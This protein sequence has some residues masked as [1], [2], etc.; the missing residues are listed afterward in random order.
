[1][2]DLSEV[3]Y[4][5]PRDRISVFTTKNQSTIREKSVNNN[6]KL[7]TSM[8]SFYNYPGSIDGVKTNSKE[9]KEYKSTRQIKAPFAT[10]K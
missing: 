2:L 5:N 7:C 8:I 3:L 6:I 9:K 4:V 1:M 10:R